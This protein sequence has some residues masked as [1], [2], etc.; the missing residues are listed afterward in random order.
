[1]KWLVFLSSFP[2]GM[3]G[4]SVHC[5]QMIAT[6]HHDGLVNGDDQFWDQTL[7]HSLFGSQIKNNLTG[8][9]VAL[10][11]LVVGRLWTQPCSSLDS[12]SRG[13][14]HFVR[15]CDA[16]SCCVV[17]CLANIAAW[18]ASRTQAMRSL[19]L[20]Q[21]QKSIETVRWGRVQ[22]KAVNALN[23]SSHVWPSKNSLDP[24]RHCLVLHSM[25]IQ[26]QRLIIST[27]VM[28]G[29]WWHTFSFIHSL[30]TCATC[31]SFFAVG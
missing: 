25:T 23:V 27:L 12:I 18:G 8:T 9:N 24:A 3:E 28:G 4:G 22:K 19:L 21:A 10:V 31:S 30:V 26:C 13:C 2:C 7:L 29:S 11:F 15:C 14:T 5:R 17:C 20:A 6:K 1:M 16:L